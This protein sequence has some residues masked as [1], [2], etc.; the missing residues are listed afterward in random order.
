MAKD[1]GVVR[2]ATRSYKHKPYSEPTQAA[3]PAVPVRPHHVG[4]ADAPPEGSVLS[5]GRTSAYLL[6]PLHS[7]G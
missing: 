3:Y 6:P 4:I 2:Q 1:A 7:L 5:I